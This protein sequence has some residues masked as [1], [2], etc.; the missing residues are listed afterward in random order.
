MTLPDKQ[1][2]CIVADPPWPHEMTGIWARERNTRPR[3]LPYDSMTLDAIAAMRV[4][5]M[6]TDDCH[7]WLWTTNRML[8]DTF[9]IMRAWGFRYLT[10]LTWVKPSGFGSWFVSTTQ[11]VLFGY[12]ERCIFPQ[13]RYLPTHFNAP[14]GEHSRKPDE[15]YKLVRQISPEPRLDLFNRR[16]INGFEGWGDQTSTQ[17]RM[18]FGEN[19]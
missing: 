19:R 12:R 3:A 14:A 1:Y 8:P 13:A 18:D 17:I 16:E 11:H 7:L 4:G 2:R 9:A 5:E 15:F 10:T 6:A